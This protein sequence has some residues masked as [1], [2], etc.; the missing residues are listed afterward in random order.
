[1]PEEHNGCT[2]PGSLRVC[3]RSRFGRKR[4]VSHSWITRNRVNGWSRTNRR[5]RTK[6][7]SRANKC[8][9]RRIEM[10]PVTSVFDRGTRSCPL[11]G[12]PSTALATAAFAL[13]SPALATAADNRRLL[14]HHQP[15]CRHGMDRCLWCRLHRADHDPCHHHTSPS[16]ALHTHPFLFHSFHSL[17]FSVLACCGTLVQHFPPHASL[18]VLHSNYAEKSCA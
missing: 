12:E 10:R 9:P 11:Q 5:N 16:H 8:C 6:G 2:Q 4:C 13:T 18:T 15:R 17:E 3:S 1:M 7:R 14:V